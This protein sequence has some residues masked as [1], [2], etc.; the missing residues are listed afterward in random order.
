MK[1]NTTLLPAVG[2]AGLLLFSCSKHEERI[3]AYGEEI[4]LSAAIGSMKTRVDDGS[5]VSGTYR[6]AYYPTPDTKGICMV[7]FAEATG[8]PLV[9]D[10]NDVYHFLKWSDVALVASRNYYLFTLD[11]VNNSTGTGTVTL[12]ESYRAATL[13]SAPDLDIVWGSKTVAPGAEKNAVAFTLS[14]KMSK[15]SLE[16]G[17]NSPGIVLDGKT[18]KITLTNVI[19]RPA[20]FNRASGAVGVGKNAPV[21]VVL[22]EG[23]LTQSGSKYVIPSWIFPPQTFDTGNWPRLRMEFDGLV[24]EGT[25]NHFMI[26]EGDTE[27]PIAMSGFEA[28]RH[29]TLRASLSPTADDVELIFMPVWIRKWV[30]IDNIGI[31]AKQRGVYTENDYRQLVEAYNQEP[32]DDKALE[33]FGT[34]NLQT[35]S[36]SFIL[37]RDIGEADAAASMPKFKDGAFELRFNGYTVYGYEDLSDLIETGGE[38]NGE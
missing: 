28:G 1:T 30:E 12:D 32:K 26:Q 5:V 2:L 37:Y 27:T 6:L 17:V 22:H 31:T 18:V 24:Y 29:L 13:E 38:D 4:R 19:D 3:P 33:K 11:N 21:E 35:N 14:H 16:I 25:L 36:W 20:T 8:Y 34:F 15:L 9:L 7:S 23:L 10:E